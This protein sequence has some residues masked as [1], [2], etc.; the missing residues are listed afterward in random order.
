MK[1]ETVQAWMR[2]RFDQDLPLEQ[3]FT[4]HLQECAA[5][6]AYRDRLNALS[7]ALT[8]LKAEEPSGQFL[9]SLCASTRPVPAQTYG[10]WAAVAVAFLAAVSA[11]VGWFNPLSVDWTV[12]L[13]AA[14]DWRAP[15]ETARGLFSPVLMLLRDAGEA[16]APIQAV[17]PV[18]PPWMFAGGVALLAGVL[19]G[20]NAF[21]RVAGENHSMRPTHHSGN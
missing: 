19:F 9:N 8:E 18:G 5:C 3:G 1:C 14:A 16:L 13:D 12:A 4:G 17:A 7:V 21:L 15:L 6:R 20:F 10:P 11:I 2:E